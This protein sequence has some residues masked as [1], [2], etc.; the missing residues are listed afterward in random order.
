[1]NSKKTIAGI[2]VTIVLTSIVVLLNGVYIVNETNQ[3]IITQFGKPVGKTESEPGLHF[4]I[5]FIQKVYKFEKR[6]LE[7][8]GDANQIPTEDKKYIWLDAYARWRISDP[9]LFFQTV[10]DERGAQTRL[11]DIIDGETRNA[12]AD[13]NLI[14]IVR[15]SNRVMRFENLPSDII[16]TSALQK[17]ELGREKIVNRI[18]KR[19]SKL[20]SEYGI[21]LVDVRLKRI[22]YSERVQQ[23]V[24][25]RMI[26][27]RL[28]IAEKY[29]S[30]G[31]GRSA[32]IE[33]QKERELKKITSEAY[34]K[35]QEIKGEADAQAAKI[36][37]QAY[38]K[39][40]EYYSFIKTLEGYETTMDEKSL[41]ILS[42]ENDYYK[43]LKKIR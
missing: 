35:S 30:E 39:D 22:N 11:D 19:S 20:A 23:K 41:L 6:W 4:K 1:M 13:N 34:R 28:R 31:E 5:P 10:Q 40:P 15:T 37:A 26:S 14:E 42:T 29:R 25:E 2:L 17:V 24:F 12:I 18:L 3:A 38:S 32:E 33:G 36:Y 27:E 8:D 21:E 43:Y 7:W 16:D 9:L